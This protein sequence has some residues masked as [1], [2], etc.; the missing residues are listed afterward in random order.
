MHAQFLRPEYVG[1]VKY[2]NCYHD[3]NDFLSLSSLLLNYYETDRNLKVE[4]YEYD[5]YYWFR[6]S[7]SPYCRLKN[8]VKEALCQLSS[9]LKGPTTCANMKKLFSKIENTS[10]EPNSY[11]G[12]VFV[13][14]RYTVT[15]EDI[16]AE[17]ASYYQPWILITPFH[18]FIR[19]FDHLMLP[20]YN[21]FIEN[22]SI[23][24]YVISNMNAEH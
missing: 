16:L 15:V 13:V 2:V 19:L 3:W 9:T 20:I 10:K 7:N 1:W 5:K 17:G 12:K 24:H 14:G 18:Y 23:V 11:I 6:K 8:L 21:S 4:R 22:N